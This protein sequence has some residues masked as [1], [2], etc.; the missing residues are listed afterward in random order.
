MTFEHLSDSR[1]AI[2]PISFQRYDVALGKGLPHL[3]SIDSEALVAFTGETPI[4]GKIDEDRPSPKRWL[5]R[6]IPS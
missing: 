6:G 3:W 4:R 1:V 2:R 5:W